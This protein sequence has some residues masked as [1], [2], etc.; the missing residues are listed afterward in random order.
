MV[1][2]PCQ[3]VPRQHRAQSLPPGHAHIPRSIPPAARPEEQPQLLLESMTLFPVPASR[4]FTHL[5][6]RQG[7][8][9]QQSITLENSPRWF[10][11]TVKSSPA[12]SPAVPI[13]MALG[14]A[15]I[16]RFILSYFQLPWW[17][18][19]PALHNAPLRSSPALAAA[20]TQK[21]DMVP[22]APW[23]HTATLQPPTS[24][25]L[26]APGDNTAPPQATAAAPAVKAGIITTLSLVLQ[27]S[28]KLPVP[29][30]SF[31]SC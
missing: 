11:S 9:L 25:A 31:L 1:P 15:G 27:Q 10:S 6:K 7:W 16:R 26:M 30:F 29:S 20:G 8:P 19:P 22:W 23:V 2:A 13:T 4:D 5:S 14:C 21:R 3:H 24:M 28:R 12:S 17:A 18:E